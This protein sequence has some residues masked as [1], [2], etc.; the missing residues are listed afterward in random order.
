MII[1]QL[2]TTIAALAVL[3]GAATATAAAPQWLESDSAAAIQARIARDFPMTISQAR[4]AIN[5]R[6]GLKLTDD[7]VREYGRRHYL[8]IKE[9]DGQERV[10]R[11]SVGN[12]ALLHPAMNGNT[13]PR[14]SKA[15]PKRIAYVD[16]ILAAYDKGEYPG[17][18]HNC[19]T[20]TY[21]DETVLKWLFSQRKAKGA[22]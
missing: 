17:V 12:L 21:G 5:E 2:R 7:S 9:I 3:T 11:K 14:G 16:T 13:P 19:W 22:R 15:S 20:R 6:Y 1:K 10:F 4:D 18:G 8:E